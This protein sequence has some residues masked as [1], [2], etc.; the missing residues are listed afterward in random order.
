MGQKGRFLQTHDYV[1]I[2]VD[3]IVG[4]QEPSLLTHLHCKPLLMLRK[5]FF[6]SVN[7]IEQARQRLVVV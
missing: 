1:N 4:L 6:Y 5:H 2:F 3:I 7:R